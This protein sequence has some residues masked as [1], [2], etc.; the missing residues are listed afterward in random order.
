MFLISQKCNRLICFKLH[1]LVCKSQLAISIFFKG[2]FKL[3]I[4]TVL[5]PNGYTCFFLFGVYRSLFVVSYL[6][7]ISQT[8]AMFNW[9]K[10]LV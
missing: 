7:M 10:A 9:G 6:Y 4:H 5:N 2:A 3:L 1:L 8:G